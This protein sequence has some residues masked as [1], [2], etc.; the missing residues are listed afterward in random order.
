ML[1]SRTLDRRDLAVE[2]SYIKIQCIGVVPRYMCVCTLVPLGATP[3]MIRQAYGGL[4]GPVSAREHNIQ[5]T[6]YNTHK[7]THRESDTGRH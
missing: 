5:H 4:Q 1:Q 2:P 3:Q 6:T 7:D